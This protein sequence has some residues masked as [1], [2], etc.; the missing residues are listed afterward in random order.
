MIKQKSFEQ[1]RGIKRGGKFDKERN[2]TYSNRLQKAQ[3]PTRFSNANENRKAEQELCL[4]PS[5]QH[6]CHSHRTGQ[7]RDSSSCKSMPYSQGKSSKE[8]QI[9]EAGVILIKIYEKG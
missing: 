9:S 3:F 4:H 1:L 6:L 2:K 7:H 8:G 5:N